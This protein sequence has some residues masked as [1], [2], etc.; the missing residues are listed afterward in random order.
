M[1]YFPDNSCQERLELLLWALPKGLVDWLFGRGLNIFVLPKDDNLAH[2]IVHGR[3]R[4]K[5]EVLAD[6]G[7]KVAETAHYRPDRN[8]I[9]I[10]HSQFFRNDGECVLHHELGH[11]VDFLYYNS[12]P[13]LSNQPEVAKALRK[14][15]P[16]SSYC[17]NKWQSSGL[18]VE[19]FATAFSAYF[20]EPSGECGELSVRNL[21]KDLI[22]ALRSTIVEGFNHV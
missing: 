16:L 7:R 22:S 5:E 14:D 11:A 10:P 12:K 17:R 19:Q 18:L 21:S 4:I 13:L 6:D 20:R 3:L 2:Q 15:F 8:L 9:I 1:I